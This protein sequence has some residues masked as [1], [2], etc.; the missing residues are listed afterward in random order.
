[1]TST[2]GPN[3]A[4]TLARRAV[5]SGADL[6]IAAGGDGTINETAQG[7]LHTGVP[8]AILPAGTANVLA[9]EL[10]INSWA[11][12]LASLSVSVPRRVAVG[13]LTRPAGVRH[14][15]M[16]AGAGLDAHIVS[17]V[18]AG[19]KART[20]K[21]AYWLAGWTLVGRRLPEFRAV[22][23]GR[24]HSCSF[25]LAARVR[26]YGGS[27]EIAREVSLLDDEFE[28]VLFE[29]V[30]AA[31]YVRYFAGMAFG[32]LRGMSGVTILRARSIRLDQPAGRVY[33]QADGELV[34]ELPAEVEIVPGA[35]TLM[36]PP[37][38]GSA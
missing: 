27:F 36:V 33:L 17:R 3:T 32:R 2:T 37:G 15:L 13:R 10:R 8:L 34:G 24:P 30:N 31:N 16:M 4:G 22:V 11:R 19:V 28:V 23:D 38:Y 35:L 29:G 14:F 1:V 7:M 12:A 21:L 26:N 20:G 6:V 18:D 25:A 5:E 9:C